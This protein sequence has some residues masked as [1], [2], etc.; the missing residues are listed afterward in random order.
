M[1]LR[2][3]VCKKIEFVLE[4]LELKKEPEFLGKSGKVGQCFEQNTWILHFLDSLFFNVKISGKI[5][6]FK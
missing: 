1:R 6:L 4:K 5:K 2:G 3:V